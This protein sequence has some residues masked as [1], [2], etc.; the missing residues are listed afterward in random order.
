MNF[1][2]YKSGTWCNA[3]YRKKKI[4]RLCV[5]KSIGDVGV[6]LV[7]KWKE[8]GRVTGRQGYGRNAQEDTST[9]G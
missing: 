4:F 5:A 6:N 7:L 1:H 8:V 2:V 3:L 9:A